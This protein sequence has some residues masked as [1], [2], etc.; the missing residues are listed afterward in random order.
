MYHSLLLPEG[1]ITTNT[2]KTKQ[3]KDPVLVIGIGGTGAKAL[4]VL[5]GKIKKQLEVKPE[6]DHIRFLEIDADVDWVRN[7][8]NIDDEEEFI[9]LQ[10]PKIKDK[11]NNKV[12]LKDL[13][14]KP[15]FQ[16]LQAGEDGAE[17]IKIPDGLNGGGG[18]RQLGRYMIINEAS[19]I[20]NRLKS[21]ITTAINGIGSADLNIHILT[22]ISGG[23]GS[24]CFLDTCYI[25]RKVLSDMAIGAATVF[26]YVFLPDVITTI[27]AIASDPNKIAGNY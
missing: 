26:G 11:F 14:S 4:D 13:I 15:Q 1:G 25:L 21:E 19:L 6:D 10:D 24:G 18:I 3:T 5:K 8:K 12:T 22:G 7:C 2:Q 17:S 20:Y 9:N 16:W 23:M 27:P